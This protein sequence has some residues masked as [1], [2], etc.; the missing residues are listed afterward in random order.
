MPKGSTSQEVAFFQSNQH[1][2]RN[3]VHSSNATE[4]LFVVQSNLYELHHGY[5]AL[6]KKRTYP[7]V[8]LVNLGEHFKS[9]RCICD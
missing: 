3:N 1:Q 2:A 8:P 4:D 6:S 5:L 7:S 9:V